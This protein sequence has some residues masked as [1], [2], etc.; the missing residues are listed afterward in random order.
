MP[1]HVFR[2][3]PF[4]LLH[5]RNDTRE[6]AMTICRE[7]HFSPKIRLELDQQITAYNLACYGM[8]IAFVGDSLI[9][10]VPKAKNLLFYKLE[11]RDSV[12][13]ISFYYKKNRYVS[14]TLA[15]FLEM[16]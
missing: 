16:I 5:E 15:A 8:G 9:Q 4:L 2:D 1:M 10:N 11:N 6:R 3:D 7:N 14:K 12:R 13:Q